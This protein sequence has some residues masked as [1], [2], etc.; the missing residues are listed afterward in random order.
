MATNGRAFVV[1]LAGTG[2]WGPPTILQGPP[3]LGLFG[4]PIAL[5]GDLLAVG[6]TLTPFHPP[7]VSVYER[8]APIRR[9]Q[10]H[11]T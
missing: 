5:S 6:S 3:E 8:A 4:V 10:A 11:S 2:G 1:R 7:T 9:R